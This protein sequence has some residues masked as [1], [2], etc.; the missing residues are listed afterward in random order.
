MHYL[1]NLF[2]HYVI[3]FS[4]YFVKFNLDTI[5][6]SMTYEETNARYVM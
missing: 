2:W 3:G 4:G 1:A 6:F 5:L